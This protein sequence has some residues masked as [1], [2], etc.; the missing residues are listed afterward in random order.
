MQRVARHAEPDGRLQAP[1]QLQLQG[2]GGRRAGARPVDRDAARSGAARVDLADRV[3]AQREGD[4]GT[5]A[6]AGPGAVEGAR[7]GLEANLDVSEA[8]RVEERLAG[9]AARA[10]VLRDAVVARVAELAVE[11]GVRQP[12][13]RVLVEDGNLTPDLRIMQSLQI[14]PFG[15]PFLPERRLEGALDRGALALALEAAE[16]SAGGGNGKF[17]VGHV[18]ILPQ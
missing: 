7:E 4:V 2:R 8:A 10:P 17:G 15:N 3:D 13:Q 16:R 1:D 11:L 18:A 9:D 6:A 5:L 14:Y 12:A